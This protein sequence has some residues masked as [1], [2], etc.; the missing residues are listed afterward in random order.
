[1]SNEVRGVDRREFLLLTS[2]CAA[3]TL[4]L[5]P[6]VFAS[7]PSQRDVAVGFLPIDAVTVA[8]DRPARMQPAD[9][10]LSSDGS[11]LSQGVRVRMAG[12]APGTGSRCTIAFQAQYLADGTQNVPVD[13]YRFERKTRLMGGLAEFGMP[14][15]VDQR[16]RFS[17][18]SAPS[19]PAL[20]LENGT[21][22]TSTVTLSLR[23]EPDVF[24]LTR[25][26]YVIVPLYDGTAAPN[27]NAT[28][29][30]S[31]GGRVVMHDVRGSELLPVNREH[32][33]LRMDYAK[34]VSGRPVDAV[35]R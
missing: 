1:M 11:F 8:T 25:G 26:Y 33:V 16:L 17:L 32:F 18:T 13:V 6:N 10:I 12:A 9:K 20:A 2:T 27:W 28:T 23:N 31:K 21:G 3:A 34:A 5:G 30:I 24:R 14:I 15:D 7:S 22:Q 4:A 19:D 35:A 29:L